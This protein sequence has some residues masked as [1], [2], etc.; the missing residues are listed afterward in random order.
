M[1]F[2]N[3]FLFIIFIISFAYLLKKLKVFNEKDAQVF[4]NYVIYFALPLTIIKNFSGINFDKTLLYIP[5]FAWFSI[6]IGLITSYF[7]GK[8]LS[9]PENSLKSFMLI[10]SFGNT[11]FLGYPFSYAF[12]GEEGLTYAII[13]DQLGSFTLV[14]TLGLFIAIG[15][16]DLKELVTFPPF[17]ALCISFLLHNLNFPEFLDYF[18]EISSA[19][20]IPVILFSLGLK[21]EPLKGFSSPKTLIAALFIKMVLLPLSTLMLLELFSL[22]GNIY[23]VILLESGMPPM[24]FAGVLALKYNLDFRLTFSAITLGIPLS[25]ITIPLFLKL[26]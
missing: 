10:S 17:I 24:V 18:L 12:F 14:I 21:F 8:L 7:L 26:L 3:K 16:L 22:K 20:L 11:A 1:E 15:R 19:S 5:L 2:Y 25:F 13:F 4:V 23:K 6:I 9:L